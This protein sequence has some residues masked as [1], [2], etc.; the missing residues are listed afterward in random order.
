MK[1]MMDQ[2]LMYYK[3]VLVYLSFGLQVVQFAKNYPQTGTLCLI[4]RSG[5]PIHFFFKDG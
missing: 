3:K 4:P 5:S 1:I 2:N